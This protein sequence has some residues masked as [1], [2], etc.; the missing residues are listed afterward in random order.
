LD[1]QSGYN[2]G[3]GANGGKA[4]IGIGGGGTI[5]DTGEVPATTFDYVPPDSNTV[6]PGDRSLVARYFAPRKGQ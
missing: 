5:V 2:S 6:D 1:L 3:R 4:G